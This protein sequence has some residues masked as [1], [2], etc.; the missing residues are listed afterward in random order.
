MG[1]RLSLKIYIFEFGL[2]K[3]M[4]LVPGVIFSYETLLFYSQ[5]VRLTID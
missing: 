4:L 2:G 5:R 1:K 3:Q